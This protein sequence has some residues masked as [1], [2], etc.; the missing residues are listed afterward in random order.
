MFFYLCSKGFS[1]VSIDK[2]LSIGHLP[3]EG[4]LLD[5]GWKFKAGDNIEWSMPH[6]DDR[7]WQPINPVKQLHRLPEVKEAGL[8]WFRIELNVDLIIIP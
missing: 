3:P 2:S 6:Y 1:Q 4:I 8:G 5:K 7:D